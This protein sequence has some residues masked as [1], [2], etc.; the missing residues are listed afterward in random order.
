MKQKKLNIQ[1]SENTTE[2]V[3]DNNSIMNESIIKQD[4]QLDQCG[5]CCSIAS[6]EIEAFANMLQIKDNRIEVV[7]DKL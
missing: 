1:L 6:R 2:S 3:S 7:E 5:L 4:N